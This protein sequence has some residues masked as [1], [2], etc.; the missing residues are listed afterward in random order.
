MFYK[1]QVFFGLRKLF[2]KSNCAFCAFQIADINECQD[3]NNGGCTDQ[4]TNNRGSYQCS[5]RRGY[6]FRRED[7]APGS[8]VGSVINTDAGR[9]CQG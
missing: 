1:V 2:V 7:E 8:G 5:C 4:C 6:E 9:L 3:G